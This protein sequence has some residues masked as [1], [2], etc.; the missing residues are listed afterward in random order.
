MAVINNI[1]AVTDAID[2]C[3]DKY[4]NVVIY[5][6]DVGFEGGV[7]RATQGLQQKYGPDRCFNAPISEALFV[8]A[9]LGM[10]MNGLLP[11]VELQFQGLGL[12]SLQNIISN[13]SRMRNRSR[14]KYTAPLVIRMPVGGGIR[15]LEHH[16]EALEAIYAHIPGIKTVMPSTPY[17]TKGL[18]CAAVESP[19]PVLFLEPSKLYRAFKQEVPDGFYTVE[20]GKGFIIN[21][22]NDLTIV[23]YGA[24]TVDCQK[25]IDLYNQK[26]PNAS[27]ELIDLRSIQPWDK[28]M[29]INS[30]KKTGRLLVVHEAVRS[31]SVSAEIIT[32]VNEDCF[33]YLRAPLSRCTGY[34]VIIPYDC[35]E[36]YHQPNPYKVL[37][38]IEKIIAYEY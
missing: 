7:F 29:V 10:A 28:K 23:T 30:V 15:A 25:A 11:I 22:G 32:T 34:D 1:K 18:L 17:D 20:I 27:I 36:T 31:F 4:K 24:Q 37:E 2:A 12:P 13:I 5:G 16:S 26:N 19:D 33:E 6:E 21:P 38:A 8:G 9:A 3:M 14:G 35:G